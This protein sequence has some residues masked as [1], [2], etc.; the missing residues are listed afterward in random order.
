MFRRCLVATL[1]VLL[2]V[3][4]L[5]GLAAPATA[6]GSADLYPGPAASD[7][8][9][10]ATTRCRAAIEWRTNAYG[11]TAAGETRIQR[12]TLFSV[13]VRAGERILTGSSSPSVGNGTPNS[14][15]KVA[16]A[17]GAD[18]VIWNPGQVTNTEAAVLPPVVDMSNGFLCSRH[19]LTSETGVISTRALEL[20]GAR[21]SDNTA[22]YEPCVY[23][24]PT[25]GLYRVAFYGTAGPTGAA[26]G[27]PDYALS[28]TPTT[29]KGTPAGTFTATA[30]S[31]VNAWDVTVRAKDDDTKKGNRLG[32]LFTYVLAGFTGGNPRPVT[33]T[34]YLNTLDGYR[35]RVNTNGFD[36]NGFVFYGNRQ[37][38][39]DADGKTPLNHDVVGQGAG[40]QQL[41][42]LVGGV[43]LAPPEYPLSFEP[44]APETLAALEIP[45]EPE[46]PKLSAVAFTGRATERGSYEGE[47]GTFTLNAETGGTYEI[48][49]SRD[50]KSFDPGLPANR[51]LRGVIPPGEA[52][53][54][55]DGKDNAGVAFPVKNAGTPQRTAQDYHVKAVLRGGEY[56]APMLDVESST[57]GG[58]SI[59]LLN[60]PGDVCPFTGAST[61]CTQVFFDDRAYT[62]SSGLFV[63]NAN[64]LLCGSFLDAVTRAARPSRTRHRHRQHEQGACLR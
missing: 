28:P 37:G 33:M 5:A 36:P 32:R 60:P 34:M 39:L 13:F 12:R 11:P 15:D 64:G 38:F 7:K 22:G 16:G 53:V 18:I 10:S 61:A 4:G 55:W 21:A 30:G 9:C 59:T 1:T 31:S 58:P 52:T 62:S 54:V 24:A 41:P 44:L 43:H 57:L 63:G 3:A 40:A 51:V 23:E 17:G 56:H 48:V 2:A 26:D 6:S 27:T 42:A 45:V 29:P 25:T 49:I 47:G 8:A 14:P 20:A 19:R 46:L 35:Y 50:G